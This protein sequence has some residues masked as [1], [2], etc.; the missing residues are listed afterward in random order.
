[1]SSPLRIELRESRAIRAILLG[2]AV[3][4]AWALQLS[5]LP[6]WSLLTVP[7]LLALAW[8]RKSSLHGDELVLRDDGSALLLAPQ[9]GETEIDSTRLQRRGWL[10]VL[11]LES[12]GRMRVHLFTPAT[13]DAAAARGLHLWFERHVQHPPKPTVV[14]GV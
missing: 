3:L 5:A 11:T 9:G 8:P 10:T 13:L 12:R 7:A 14:P 4:A 6:A 1:M 2:L